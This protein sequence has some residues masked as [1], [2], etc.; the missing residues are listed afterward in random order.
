M[1][2]FAIF[3]TLVAL[4]AACGAPPAA[5]TTTADAGAWTLARKREWAARLRADGLD[6][7]AADVYEKI[8]AEERGLTPELVAGL[9]LSIAEIHV[10]AGRDA[11]ALASLYRARLFD[12]PDER[13]RKVDT[14]TIACLERL[15]RGAAADRLLDKVAGLDAKGGEGTGSEV[16]VAEIGE[17]KITRGQLEGLIAASNLREADPAELEG[18]RREVLRSLVAQRVLVRKARKLGYDEDDKVRLAT[19]LAAQEVLVRKVVAEELKDEVAVTPEDAKLFYDAR[20]ELF[21]EAGTLRVAQILVETAEAEAEVRAALAAGGDFAELARKRSLDAASAAKGGV[22]EE[23]L[24]EGREHPVFARP[25][26]VFAAVGATAEGEVAAESL[27]SA[28]GRHVLRVIARR[29]WRLRPFE[30]VAERAARGLRAEREKR[31]MDRLMQGAL[32][33]TDVVIHEDRLK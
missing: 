12:L 3:A 1:R 23:P 8:I 2:R 14:M 13:R 5:E 31:A 4:L 17:E 27:R 25:A 15:G 22:V 24:V 7:L 33:S 18:R 28:R 16:V 11:D 9:S 10:A 29:E 32:E 21:R 26:D 6:D 30:E 19:E 20:P